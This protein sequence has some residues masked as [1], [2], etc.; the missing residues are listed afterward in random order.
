MRKISL[1]DTLTTKLI[2]TIKERDISESDV[3]KQ[4][5]K[6]QIGFCIA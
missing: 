1:F 4:H 5:K 2:T 3:N 6:K